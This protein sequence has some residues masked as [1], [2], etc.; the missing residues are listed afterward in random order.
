M[1]DLYEVLGI[2]RNADDREIKRAYRKM[3]VQHHPD[4]GGDEQ[5]FKELSEAYEILHD[6]LMFFARQQIHE[7]YY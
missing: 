5:K 7:I 3:A 6:Q 2:S 1:K 4:K